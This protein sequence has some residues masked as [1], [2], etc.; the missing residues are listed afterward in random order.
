MLLNS[1]HFY[2]GENPRINTKFTLKSL[3]VATKRPIHTT[4]EH[5]HAYESH[6]RSKFD[7]RYLHAV[8]TFSI[9]L[10]THIR[11]FQTEQI[12]PIKFYNRTQH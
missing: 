1:L 2:I 10:T 12:K 8:R 7:T 6:L 4:Q 9:S 11:H 5:T 3:E